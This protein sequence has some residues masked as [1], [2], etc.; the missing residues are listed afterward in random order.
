MNAGLFV[1][2]DD[3]I[4]GTQWSALPDA[5]VKI[6]DGS[7]FVGKVGIARE[8]PASMLPRAQAWTMRKQARSFQS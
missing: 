7:G 1:C 6:Q 2:G 8:D 5:F 4:I 3:V